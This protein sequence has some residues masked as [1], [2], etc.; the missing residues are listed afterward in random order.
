MA[1]EINFSNLRSPLSALREPP[2]IYNR[3]VKD[4]PRA[5]NKDKDEERHQKARE[6][7][8]D[9]RKKTVERL[10]KEAI[11]KVEYN[12]VQQQKEVDRDLQRMEDF[13]SSVHDKA[14]QP[15]QR[16][17]IEVE[18]PQSNRRSESLER[19]NAVAASKAA[20]ISLQSNGIE[21]RQEYQDSQDAQAAREATREAPPP[22]KADPPKDP[23]KQVEKVD[24]EV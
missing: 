13:R 20:M 17:K 4:A 24:I 2:N 18:L 8:A 3:V 9:A 23:P 15:E 1:T 5:E 16:E 12:Q 10:R 6:G 21:R 14:Y 22:P 7:N 11:Q 19:A